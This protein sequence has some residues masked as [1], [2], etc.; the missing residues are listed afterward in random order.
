MVEITETAIKTEFGDPFVY[1]RLGSTA[2]SGH[3][4]PLQDLRQRKEAKGLA[5]K[6]FASF[7]ESMF[8]PIKGLHSCADSSVLVPIYRFVFLAPCK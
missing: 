5:L 2:T 8:V 3:Y 4:K 6:G 7:E 1:R